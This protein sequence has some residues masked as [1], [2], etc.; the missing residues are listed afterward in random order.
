MPAH[1]YSA[2][3]RIP[4]SEYQQSVREALAAV[5]D[6]P[7]GPGIETVAL[8]HAC[9]RRLATDLRS[10]V[11][12]PPLA[13]SQMDGFAYRVADLPA[14]PDVPATDSCASLRLGPMIAA[15]A[16]PGTL[17]PGRAR[18]IMTGAPLPEGATAVVPVEETTVEAFDQLKDPAEAHAQM[19]S[20]VSFTVR[21]HHREEGRFVRRAGSDTDRGDYV[22]RAGT[23]VTPRLVGHLAS[24]G[25]TRVDVREALR[26]IVVSTGSELAPPG[27]EPH[28]GQ[29]YDANSPAL[30]SALTEMGV[31][32]CELLRVP[33]DPV[34]L[35]EQVRGALTTHRAHLVVSSGGVSAGAV[36][37]I[38]QLTEL[39][40]PP[41]RLAFHKVAM[42]PGGPQGLGLIELPDGTQAAWLALPGNPVSALVSVEMFLREGIG[43]M[44]RARVRIPVRTLTGEPEASPAGMLQVRRARL[45]SDGTARFV[46]GPSSHLLGALALSDA[47]VLVAPDCTLVTDRSEHEV[48]ILR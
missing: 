35:W 36:E 12:V 31:E 37:P 14:F 32:V 6:S 27:A 9:G 28:N 10:P 19:P 2:A 20:A 33:D 39:E 17:E 1:E 44:P 30:A 43:A 22:A 18:P 7:A 13:N 16:A 26:A 5:L 45:H 21:P 46:G 40:P 41:V 23:H 3:A 24:V 25:F 48:M 8:T 15:G 42:Q 29:I 11:Q 47:L 4:V 38:R 34:A